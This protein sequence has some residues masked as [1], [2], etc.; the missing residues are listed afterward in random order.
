[1]ASAFQTHRDETV[2]QGGGYLVVGVGLTDQPL[3]VGSPFHVKFQD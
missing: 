3:A 2:I 1:M